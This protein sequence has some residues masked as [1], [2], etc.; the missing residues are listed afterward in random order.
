VDIDDISLDTLMPAFVKHDFQL[1]IKILTDQLARAGTF[2]SAEAQFGEIMPLIPRMSDP[3]IKALLERAAANNQVHHANLC[4][5]EYIPS[6]L[7]SHGSLLKRET[8]AFLKKVC[9]RYA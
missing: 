4:A 9:A 8:R 7:K 1:A 2:R 5:R 6:I 3:Q